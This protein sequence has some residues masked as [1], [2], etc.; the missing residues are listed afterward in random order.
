MESLVESFEEGRY[1]YRQI[2]RQ[3]SLAIFEQ[4]HK[5]NP[6]VV[7][8][9]VIRIRIQ[10]AHTWPDG[11]TTPEK[12]AY[13]PSSAWGRDGWTFFTLDAARAHLQILL[14]R[15]RATAGGMVM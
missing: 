12:E 2:D 13:P 10:R 11:T 3:G 1:R 9:E 6:R 8:F 7:R 15:E 4:R 14:Q 5:D